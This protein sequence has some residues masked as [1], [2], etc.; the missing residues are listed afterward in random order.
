MK[1]HLGS[2][3]GKAAASYA[4]NFPELPARHWRDFWGRPVS[5]IG[6]GSYLGEPDE[7]TDQLYVAAMAAAVRGGLNMLDTAINYRNQRSEGCVAQALAL[8]DQEGIPRSAV[9][10]ATKGGFL[11]PDARDPRPA[12]VYLHEELIQTGVVKTDDIVAGCHVMT[13]AYLRHQIQKS[14]SNM[15]VETLDV[16]HLHNIEMQI[17]H[18]G[19]EEFFA[20]LALAF[21]ALETEAAAGRIGVYGLATWNGF[22]VA[23]DEPNFHGLQKVWDTARAVGGEHHH[24]GAIQLPVNLAMTEGYRFPNQPRGEDTLSTLQLAQDLNLFVFA[25]AS[26]FQGQLSRGLAPGLKEKLGSPTDASAAIQFTRSTPGM[27][28]ALVGLK[29]APHVVEAL[30]VAATSPMEKE[31]FEGLWG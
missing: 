31:I 7:A 21:E 23:P 16:Y 1:N 24:F 18:L 12:R 15:Q 29:S 6:A 27:G 22:R 28:A 4:Q 11:S 20:A 5:S 8:L 2:F 19:E 10:L 14:L 3:D 30:N 26:L 25:S 13:P 17:E 9:L